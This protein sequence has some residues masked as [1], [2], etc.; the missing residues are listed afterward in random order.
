MIRQSESLASGMV[1]V[2]VATLCAAREALDPDVE[3]LGGAPER[4]VAC[5]R[6]ENAR[7]RGAV[8]AEEAARLVERQRQAGHV[9]EFAADAADQRVAAGLIAA[10]D[11]YT[12][13]E[14]HANRFPLDL[15]EG[16][17]GTPLFQRASLRTFPFYS[18]APP[19]ARSSRQVVVF[20]FVRGDQ[21]HQ[22]QSGRQGEVIADKWQ[23]VSACQPR[24]D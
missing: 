9:V 16:H 21:A 7:A 17:I 20:C 14:R 3:V 23:A 11:Q 15:V 4:A 10:L 13:R 18:R 19:L 5:Q 22:R 12:V 1:R 6:R 8:D 2:V 24:R